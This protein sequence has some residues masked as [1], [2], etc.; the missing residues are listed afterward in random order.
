MS[1]TMTG[2]GRGEKRRSVFS[3]LLLVLLTV[4]LTETNAGREQARLVQLYT[5]G[6][7]SDER[8]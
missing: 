2:S 3:R 5:L 8:S 6:K 7:G 4:G 1:W